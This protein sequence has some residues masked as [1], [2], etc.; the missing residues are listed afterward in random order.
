MKYRDWGRR[1]GGMRSGR[2]R[3]FL[4]GEGSSCFLL[5]YFF[6]FI[7]L[8]LS[9]DELVVTIFADFIQSRDEQIAIMSNL[10]SE[11]EFEQA[12]K[13]M[14]PRPRSFQD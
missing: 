1:V 13:G 4:F 6:H 8:V 10:P 9:S 5:L 7:Y 2:E 11:P 3:V 12:Y 14:T